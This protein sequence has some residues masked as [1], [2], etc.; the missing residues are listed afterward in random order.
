MHAPKKQK[1]ESLFICPKQVW[2]REGI[3]VME[4]SRTGS[5]MP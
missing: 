3:A 2:E 5:F 1:L 4:I